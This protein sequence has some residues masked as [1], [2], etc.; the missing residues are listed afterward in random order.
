[1]AAARTLGVVGVDRASGDGG[2]GVG[3]EARLVEGVGVDGELGAALLADGEAG[4][5]RRGG[6]PQSSWILKPTAPARSWARME[7]YEVVL[8]L[9]SR[10]MLRGYTSIASN[11]RARCQEPGVMVVALLP[12]AG[13]VPPPSRV[14][15]PE[16]RASSAAWG[17][18]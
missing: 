12:S 3:D 9:P 7:S 4:V 17:G 10:P 8:P 18:R 1:M 11:I 14:V 2:E 16:A 5:D 13:P 15:M 6:G